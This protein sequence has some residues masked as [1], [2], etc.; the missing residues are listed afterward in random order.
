MGKN[1]HTFEPNSRVAVLSM[2]K[3]IPPLKRGCNLSSE[4]LVIKFITSQNRM[5]IFVVFG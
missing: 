2:I 3:D 5:R 1:Y 4:V